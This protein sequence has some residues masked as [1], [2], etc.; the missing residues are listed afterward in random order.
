MNNVDLM[1]FTPKTVT[2]KR[3][4]LEIIR[5]TV[6]QGYALSHEELIVGQTSIAATIFK[7]GGQLAAS[8]SLS[9]SSDKVMGPQKTNFI[10][11]LR[12][13]AIEISRYMGH[14]PM[15]PKEREKSE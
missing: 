13:T 15:V 8:I 7:S 12:R 10:T 4:L 6:E 11:D 9:G 1:P 3:Q 5:Q 14:F 2:D